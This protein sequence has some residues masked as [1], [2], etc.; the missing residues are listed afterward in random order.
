MSARALL[1]T[2][3]RLPEGDGDERDVPAALADVGLEAEWAAWDDPAVDFAAADIVILRSTW[4]YSQRRA[5]FLERCRTIP[6]LC[7]GAGVV[8]WNTDKCYLSDLAA[9]GL[10]IVPT[11]LVAPGTIPNWPDV[12][13][14]LK[15]AVGV[16]SIGAGRFTPGTVPAAVRHLAELHGAGQTV[17]LQPYQSAVDT[18]G[19]T[20]LV[21]FGGLYSHA[22]TKAA[23][24]TGAEADAS[25]LFVTERLGAAVPDASMRALA[26]DALDTAS[27]LLGIRRTDL[28]YARVDVLRADDGAPALLELELTEPSLGFGH[29]DRGAPLRFASAVRSRLSSHDPRG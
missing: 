11:E 29:A 24:L 13:F 6:A 10:R 16:G 9:A 3:A 8:R 23:M 4:D 12:D 17:L 26:E 22:F 25:G 2:C 19:E 14:V 28:L 15:P 5:E 7:N 18:E 20:A 21:F 1:L 27:E